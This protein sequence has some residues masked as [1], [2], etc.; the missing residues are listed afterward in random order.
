[1]RVFQ[2]LEKRLRGF[3]DKLHPLLYRGS[4]RFCPVCGK[5]ARRFRDAGRKTWRRENAICPFCR[6]R[7]R[8]RLLW[9]FLQQRPGLFS[10]PRLD[11]MH[12]APEPALEPFLRGRAGAGYL[13]VDIY[14]D[15]VMEKMDITRIPRS[16]DS[17]DAIVCVHVIQ[18][19]ADDQQALSELFR[20]LRP[21]GWAVLN[22]PMER[23]RQTRVQKPTNK[24]N[25]I[26]PNR[27]DGRHRFYG[28]DY[29]DT[30]RAIGF[31][32]DEVAAADLLPKDQLVRYGL[33]NQL[34]T[35]YVHVCSKPLDVGP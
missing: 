34:Y 24:S 33:D 13:S 2:S 32:V 8:D 4:A 23:G 29:R 25:I 30:L 15:N 3:R 5:T 21:G 27:P 16:D 20:V 18:N 19:I 22:V 12:V 10:S 14:L 26:N 31:Q 9:L 28:D 17:F 35:G 7:E 6:S 11:L 1:M